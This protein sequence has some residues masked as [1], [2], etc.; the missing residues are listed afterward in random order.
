[1][2]LGLIGL[3]AWKGL[4][5]ILSG[6]NRWT[7]ATLVLIILTLLVAAPTIDETANITIMITGRAIAEAILLIALV[8][9]AKKGLDSSDI[10]SWLWETWRFVKQ[11][12]LCC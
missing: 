8:M 7:T 3:F 10:S 4:E 2:L 1:M 5:T 12:F 9:V 6:A 11:I